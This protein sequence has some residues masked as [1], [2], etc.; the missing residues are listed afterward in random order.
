MRCSHANDEVV[1]GEELD[2]LESG[3]SGV[4]IYIYIKGIKGHGM[5]VMFAFT[6]CHT[7][8]DHKHHNFASLPFF[9]SDLLGATVGT[10]IS[11]SDCR[12]FAKQ[13][14]GFGPW[15][16]APTSESTVVWNESPKRT[17]V[18]IIA[19]R[20]H[21]FWIYFMDFPTCKQSLYRT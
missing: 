6:F 10:V 8:S 9:L 13:D 19:A 17:M 7:A 14:S 11:P 2:S 4:N 12:R 21:F 20:F 1:V 5:A 16:V 3:P 15:L 18:G